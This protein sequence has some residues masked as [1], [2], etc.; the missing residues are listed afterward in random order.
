MWNPYPPVPA[1]G[2]RRM[3]GS[4]GSF[5]N[6]QMR[7]VFSSPL[8]FIHGLY[9][10]VVCVSCIVPSCSE[11]QTRAPSAVLII[12][13]CDLS[14]PLTDLDN[15]KCS[16]RGQHKTQLVPEPDGTSPNYR[17]SPSISHTPKFP[18]ISLSPSL[19]FLWL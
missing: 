10:S 8:P 6:D 4:N 1:I 17:Y 13:T 2:K 3:R 11:P 9:Q 15:N 19:R 14:R 5:L 16:T 18:P 7:G 12:P